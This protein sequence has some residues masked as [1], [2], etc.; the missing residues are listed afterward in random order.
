[1]LHTL[2]LQNCEFEEIID[3][4]P[5]VNSSL[6]ELNVEYYCDVDSD[7]DGYTVKQQR[8]IN[9]DGIKPDQLQL[10]EFKALESNFKP[11][12]WLALKKLGLIK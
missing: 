5:L 9:V 10:Q 7:E 12:D 11:A 3:L 1:M 8:R 2:T 6:K 4:R